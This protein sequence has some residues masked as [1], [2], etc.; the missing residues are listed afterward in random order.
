MNE[1]NQVPGQIHRV[2]ILG[3]TGFVGSYLVDAL[4]EQGFH[5]VLLVRPGS[6][7]RVEQRERCTLVGGDIDDGDAIRK[8]AED[9]DALIYN[10]GILREFPERGISFDRLQDEAARH[11]MD[12]AV[13]AGVRRFLLMSANGVEAGSTP[14]Q[15][16]KLRAERYLQSLDLDWTIFRPSV[17]FGD[18]RGRMEF[19]TQLCA[20]IIDSPLPAPL[21]HK[22]LLPFGAG[23]FTLSP[24]HVADVAAAFVAA[25]KNPGTVGST[26]H[27]GGPE[28]ISWREI[29]QRLAA[30]RGRSK[31]ML[32]APALGVM[33]AAALLDRFESFPI[34]RDQIRMLLDGNACAADDLRSL[35]I[36]PTAFSAPA[37]DYL[38]PQRAAA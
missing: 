10:I 26:L 38:E 16:S 14:Y 25:L 36:E 32:P 7:D 4:L 24:V 9:S 23:A 18:P 12:A 28:T 2:G 3:G 35:G 1:T 8:V 30:A 5:P 29:L 13:A 33:A 22:G 17:L 21:F 31:L 37:L 19:A 6:E 20:E 34:T 27:L 11:A 15:R